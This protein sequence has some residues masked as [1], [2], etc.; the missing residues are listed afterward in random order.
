MRGDSARVQELELELRNLR[1]AFEE[2]IGSSREL[3][4]GL[5]RE[6]ADM[7]TF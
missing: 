4:D 3:E 6:L 2:Y 7:R 5:D 1:V